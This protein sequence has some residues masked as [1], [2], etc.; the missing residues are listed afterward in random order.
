LVLDDDVGYDAKVDR[1]DGVV[2][3]RV[4]QLEAPARERMPHATGLRMR[5][6]CETAR[7]APGRTTREPIAFRHDDTHPSQGARRGDRQTDDA[8]ADHENV[9][10]A[11]WFVRRRRIE[12]VEVF[13]TRLVL[14]DGTSRAVHLFRLRGTDLVE[15]TR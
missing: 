2:A 15:S 5:I 3:L 6:R 1:L 13:G 4:M 8:A 7:G 12:C 9:G 14:P 10:R 11:R